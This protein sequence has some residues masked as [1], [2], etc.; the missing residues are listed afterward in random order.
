MRTKGKPRILIVDDVAII[1]VLLS[2]ILRE[3]YN[4]VAKASS[5]EEALEL[6]ASL[7]PDLVCLDINLPSMSGLQTLEEI[8]KSH[9]QL[10]VVMI[11]ADTTQESVLEAIEKGA[12]NYII[13][14]FN[15]ERVLE[16]ISRSI[17]VDTSAC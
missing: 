13:K 3:S 4:V 9:P 11:T 17:G 6:C 14:P 7:G 10:P 5:G 15:A 12:N 2:T 16:T 1:R 8:R